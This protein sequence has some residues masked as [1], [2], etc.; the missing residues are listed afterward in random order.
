[1][2]L[3]GPDV[4]V[5]AMANPAASSNA[6]LAVELEAAIDPA[7]VAAALARLLI[8]CPW[9]GGRLVRPRPW[10]KLAWRVPH[11]CPTPPP[12]ATE[13]ITAAGI[14][15]LVDR[16]LAAPIDPY[17]HPPLRLTIADRAL[18]L[19]WAHALMDPRGAEY[20]VRLLADLDD[21]KSPGDPLI[22]A[23]PE[24]RPW[25]ARATLAARGAASLRE[26]APR[27]P[28]SLAAAA[29]RSGGASDCRHR[30]LRFRETATADRTRRGL[31]WRLAVVARALTPLWVRR[32]L[33]TDVPFLVPVSVDRRPRGEPGPVL[34]N[35]L[36]F[37]FA[38][39][40]LPLDGDVAALARALRTDLVAAVR[41]DDLEAGWAG[42]SFARYRPLRSMFRELPWTRDGDLCSFHFADTG[43]LLP[44]RPQ[45]FGARLVGGYHVAAVPARPGLGVFFGRRDGVESLTLSWTDGVLDDADVAEVAGVV[46]RELEWAPA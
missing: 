6:V 43:D 15:S 3:L 38:R 40:P 35:H 9:I 5:L 31:P 20:L 25:R 1:M 41:R 23:P 22:V 13:P 37:H 10:G 46:A 8:V 12:L 29:A 30:R 33:P 44:D 36:A 45:I 4:V 24:T 18:V 7:R 2:P 34:G 21:G 16:E 39:C 11:A 42:M 26:L 19:T 17:R 27:P 32:G 14:E 28:V